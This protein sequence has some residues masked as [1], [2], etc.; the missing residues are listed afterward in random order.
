MFGYGRLQ[1]QVGRMLRAPTRK[2]MGGQ[3]ELGRLDDTE[4]PRA[5]WQWRQIG[6]SV[7]DNDLDPQDPLP[8]TGPYA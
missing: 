2:S 7:T 8:A 3:S 1:L 4:S 6:K 5:T